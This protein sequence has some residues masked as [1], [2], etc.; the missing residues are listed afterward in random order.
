LKYQILDY[1]ECGLN[2]AGCEQVCKNTVG[3]YNCDCRKGF[4]LHANKNGCKGTYTTTVFFTGNVE[5]QPM[6]FGLLMGSDSL[7]NPRCQR[8]ATIDCMVLL[9]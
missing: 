6:V 1:N 8:S 7:V 2:N 4:E 5:Y 9:V 3:S